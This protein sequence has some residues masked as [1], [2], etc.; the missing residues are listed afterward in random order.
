MEMNF[1]SLNQIGDQSDVYE[2]PEKEAVLNKMVIRQLMDTLDETEQQII[3]LRYFE[4]KTQCEV[5][6][7][8]AVTQVQISRNERKIL[9]KLGQ[10]W[11]YNVI[12]RKENLEERNHQ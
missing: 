6:G 9:A 7:I 12:C 3:R 5:A 11:S 10:N 1:Y 2:E 8:L 4:N